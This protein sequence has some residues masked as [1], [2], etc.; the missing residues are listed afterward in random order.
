M[1]V[2]QDRLKINQSN[3]F[4]SPKNISVEQHLNYYP[5]LRSGTSDQNAR[6]ARVALQ[7]S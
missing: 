3:Q 6:V 1:H 7:I 4:L 2:H 5:H